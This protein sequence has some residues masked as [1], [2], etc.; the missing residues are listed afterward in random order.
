MDDLLLGIAGSF[1]GGPW[2]ASSGT[3]KVKAIFIRTVSPI[4]DRSDLV[5]M[6]LAN[7]Q[8][9]DALTGYQHHLL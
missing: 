8:V 4:S 7:V 1:V 3:P 9:A 2:G 5:V 6:A